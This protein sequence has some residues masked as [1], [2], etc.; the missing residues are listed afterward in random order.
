M[1]KPNRRIIVVLVLLVASLFLFFGG[2]QGTAFGLEDS[3]VYVFRLETGDVVCDERG[4]SVRAD[5]P[6]SFTPPLLSGKF[7]LETL[8][9]VDSDV[10]KGMRVKV[11]GVERV[12]K[13][14]ER[15]VV[16]DGAE[17]FYT[18]EKV[19]LST[20]Q[21]VDGS[22]KE[23][24]RFFE[25]HY[26]WRIDSSKLKV[27]G[28]QPDRDA[29]FKQLEIATYDVKDG[30]NSPFQTGALVE[31]NREV[32][33]LNTKPDGTIS[34]FVPTDTLGLQ[35]I[36]LSPYYV[37]K[38]G[39]REFIVSTGDKLRNDF[40]VVPQQTGDEGGIP[41]RLVEASQQNKGILV[42]GEKGFDTSRVWLSIGIAVIGSLVIYLLFWR[43]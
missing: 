28:R 8:D 26:H 17:F 38:S 29:F 35:R 14:N 11:S 19:V 13:P 3:F 2:L 37:F 36:E 7:S 43:R 41:S 10:R 16:V 32:Q 18:P 4:C 23:F 25:V 24:V 27:I 30:L 33:R 34:L 15:V 42:A 40:R 12:I 39:E 22:L 21:L 31:V 20:E 1:A 9:A 6:F 5:K